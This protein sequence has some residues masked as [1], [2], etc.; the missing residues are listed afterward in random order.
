MG[1][2]LLSSVRRLVFLGNPERARRIASAIAIRY[3]YQLADIFRVRSGRN[4]EHLHAL[5]KSFMSVSQPFQSFID[6]HLSALPV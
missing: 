5:R 6:C 1:E 2:A 3:L 4:Q